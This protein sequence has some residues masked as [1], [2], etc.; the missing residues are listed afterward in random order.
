MGGSNAAVV[1]G[2]VSRMF[3]ETATILAIANPI[4]REAVLQKLLPLIGKDN[5]TYSLSSAPLSV[6]NVAKSSIPQPQAIITANTAY[7]FPYSG[8]Y[9]DTSISDP[10][11]ATDSEGN[12]YI[13]YIENTSHWLDNSPV[14]IETDVK[15]LS[16]KSSSPVILDT[17]SAP[18]SGSSRQYFS[19]PSISIDSHDN[20]HVTYEKSIDIYY[21]ENWQDHY[22]HTRSI[23][24]TRL[25][26]P[27]TIELLDGTDF[28]NGREVTNDTAKLATGGTAMDGVATD[29]VARL[30]LR[31]RAND[32]SPLTLSLQGTGN[33]AE[34]GI[35][36][37]ID[38]SDE[39]DSI[40]VDPVEIDGKQYAFA[41]YQAPDSF[42]RYGH[43]AE[44]ERALE[45]KITLNVESDADSQPT[46]KDIKLVRPPLILIHGLWS[47]PGMWSENNFRVKLGTAVPGLR[48]FAVNYTGTNDCAFIL[49]KYK[50]SKSI[51]DAKKQFR[52]NKIAMTQADVLGHSMGGLLARIWAGYG[53][54]VYLRDD[55]YWMGDIHKLITLDSPHNGAFLADLSINAVSKVIPAVRNWIITKCR[56]IG[57][58]IDGGAIQDLMTKSGAISD[59]NGKEISTSAH[60][61]IGDYTVMNN[62]SMP[63][64]LGM[65]YLVLELFCDPKPYII[66]GHSDLVVSVESQSG[67]LGNNTSTAFSHYH[68]NAATDNVVNDTV[69]LLNS[70]SNSGLFRRGF[71]SQ[72]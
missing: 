69:E 54:I 20:I 42:V 12:W 61:I 70:Y 14:D 58:P 38:G 17:Y 3:F 68:T 8:A 45:R 2:A 19:S 21:H 28:T 27:P 35:L 6:S 11:I 65:L 39:G 50:V 32:A 26:G 41:I 13:A 59:M 1:N 43:E 7:V 16:S 64:D 10:H 52:A 9:I 48:M 44:D 63:P 22:Q 62:G 36:R 33:A 46:P 67:G 57:K 40:T 18:A 5:R 23:M 34:D 56:S 71:P 53:K 15:C 24:C 30:L 51:E 60:S 47:G 37:A 4:L 66:N 72:K 29:G 25:S 49:N 31:L 55:N